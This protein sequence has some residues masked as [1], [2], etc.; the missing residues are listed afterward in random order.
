MLAVAS[1]SQG[2]N[3]TLVIIIIAAVTVA[4]CWRFLLKVGI[5]LLIVGFLFVFV[6]AALDILHGLHALIP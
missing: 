5:A 1:A 6:S 4:V 2:L 3:S